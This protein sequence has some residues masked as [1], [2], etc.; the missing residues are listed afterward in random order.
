MADSTKRSATPSSCVTV[1]DVHVP[2]E[3]F[4][5]DT[6]NLLTVTMN[7][8]DAVFTTSYHLCLSWSQVQT[9][10]AADILDYFWG[11]GHSSTLRIR[12][13]EAAVRRACT[14]CTEESTSGRTTRAARTAKWTRRRPAP[15]H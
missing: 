4:P 6:H 3:H 2:W 9:T 7:S 5:Q 12:R 11:T 10:K 8:H 13:C 15:R 14:T 1:G